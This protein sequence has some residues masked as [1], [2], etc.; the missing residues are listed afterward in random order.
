MPSPAAAPSP[1]PSLWLAPMAEITDSPFR[2]IAKS[3]GADELVSEMISAAGLSRGNLR[4]RLMLEHPDIEPQ[5]FRVQLYGGD[6]GEMAEA[7]RIAAELGAAAIDINAGCPVPKVLKCGGGAALMRS[8]ATIGDM[9]SKIR[10]A[11]QLPVTVKTRIGLHPGAITIF[12]VLRAAEDNG[13]SAIAVHGRFASAGHGGPANILILAKTVAAA[14]IPVTVNGGINT[15]ANALRIHRETAAAGLMIGRAAIGRPWI[16][17][18]IRAAFQAAAAAPI[19]TPAAAA[20]FSPEDKEKV[21]RGHMEKIV[22]HYSA[23]ASKYPELELDP[24]KPALRAFTSHLFR[25]FSG[26]SGSNEIRRNMN[27]CKT[28]REIFELIAAQIKAP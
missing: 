27:A 6:P 4:T 1:A 7:S 20:D 8:P 9:V 13:A 18:E 16:F 14:Q 23:L 25:Y 19:T 5:P 26:I 22:S 21:F 17:A 24:E 11:S 3:F 15:A 28:V 12:D 10:A 2:Q